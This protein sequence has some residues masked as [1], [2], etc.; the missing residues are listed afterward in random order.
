MNRPIL[1]NVGA[2]VN[3]TLAKTVDIELAEQERY[4]PAFCNESGLSACIYGDWSCSR[5]HGIIGQQYYIM[6]PSGPSTSSTVSSM[7]PQSVAN[8][9]TVGHTNHLKRH[10]A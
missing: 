9:E 7:I 8:V 1:N 6:I 10:R 3:N 2:A 4:M 5:T